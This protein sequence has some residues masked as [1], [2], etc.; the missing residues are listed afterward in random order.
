MMMTIMILNDML[1]LP[2]V[3]DGHF[4]VC[5]CIYFCT[6]TFYYCIDDKSVFIRFF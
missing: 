1:S 5:A 3:V 6:L 4:L 2:Y